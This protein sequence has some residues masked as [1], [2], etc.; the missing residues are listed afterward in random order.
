MTAYRRL[1]VFL[2]LDYSNPFTLLDQSIQQTII[3]LQLSQNLDPSLDI[4]TTLALPMTLGDD[5]VIIDLIYIIL[6]TGTVPTTRD[7]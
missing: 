5:L 2:P 3:E 4:Y 7:G 6:K 1:S